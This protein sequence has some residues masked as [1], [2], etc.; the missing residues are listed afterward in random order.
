MLA[1]A[2]RD[3]MCAFVASITDNMAPSVA[4]TADEMKAWGRRL[5]RAMR[6]GDVVG[7]VGPLGAGKTTL[8][9]GIAE[10][11]EISAHRHVASPTFA[12]VNEHPGRVPLLHADL[13]RVGSA[14]ELFELGLDEAFDRAAAVIEWLDRIPSAVPADHLRITISIA[15]D[16][17]RHLELCA[18]GPSSE[19]LAK[20]VA[21]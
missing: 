9:Q 20:A 13:Y 7:L 2:A 16:G 15:A 12:L 1:T 11:M 6:V 19:R 10:G 14:A 17:A 4:A 5:G 8:T 18:A 21:S 3:K